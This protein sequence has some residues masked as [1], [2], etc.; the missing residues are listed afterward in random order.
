MPQLHWRAGKR[1]QVYLSPL[2]EWFPTISPIIPVFSVPLSPLP[3][4]CLFSC[5]P[6]YCSAGIVVWIAHVHT[7]ISQPHI[8]GIIYINTG[9]RDCNYQDRGI[10]NKPCR[11]CPSWEGQWPFRAKNPDLRSVLCAR[12]LFQVF[13]TWAFRSW[14]QSFMN[15]D[16][17]ALLQSVLKGTEKSRSNLQVKY[18][19]PLGCRNY[20]GDLIC[21][22]FPAESLKY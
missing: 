17:T 12:G 1:E 2:K 19:F 7:D 10:S 8:S 14:K 9:M 16:N 4:H 13:K 21:H 15:S 5:F 18:I 11:K 3:P 22:V 6:Q 20:F